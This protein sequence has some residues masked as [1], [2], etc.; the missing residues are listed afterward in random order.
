MSAV[1]NNGPLFNA[2]PDT[3]EEEF[4][5]GD[6]LGIVIE[7]RWLIIASTAIALLIGA[8]YNFVATP[9]YQA[10]GLLQVEERT[11]GVGDLDVATMFDTYTPPI[12]ELEILRSRTVLGTVVDD[13]GLQIVAQPNY[14]PIFG[15][16]LARRA[17]PD[18]RPL[19]KVDSLE[20]PESM[21]G[22]PFSLVALNTGS[23][24]LLGPEEELVLRGRIGEPASGNSVSLF[25]SQLQGEYGQQF[26][27]LKR[28]R[29]SSIRSLQNNLTVAE[30]G[31]W[32]GILSIKV[33]GPD[34][35]MARH[36]VDGIA[37]AYVRQNVE[38]KSEEAEKTLAFLDEQ[39]PIVKRDMEAAEVALNTY[40]LEQGSIDLPL[41]TQ[42][43]LQTIVKIEGQLNQLRQERDKVTQA[44]TPEHPTVI[45]LDT[46]I[47][48]LQAELED[49]ND[50]VREL[51]TTQQEVLRLVRDAEVNRALYTSLLN[52]AQELRVVKAGTVGNVRVLDYAVT[53]IAPIKP[54]KDNV[55]LL[56]LFFGGLTGMGLAFLR[57]A[58]HGG[59]VD[60]DLIEKRVNIPVYATI[61]HSKR[62]V[63]LYKKL[64]TKEAKRAILAVD[65]P[66]DSAIESIK[67]LTTALHFGMIDAKNSCI[68]IAGPSPEVGKSFV[69]INLAAALAAGG[70]TVLLI[71]GDLR[72]GHLHQY[73]GISRDNGLSE[74][75]SG[76]IPIGDALH[77]TTVKG[78]TFVPT[79]RIPPNP[80][81]LLLHKR[82]V[83]CLSVLTPRFDHIIIDSPPLLA[84]TDATI[85]GQ[86]AGA[87]L[88]VLRSGEHPMR[89][90]EQSV[91]RLQNANVNLRGIIVNDSNIAS[92]R[93]GAGKYSYQYT[94]DKA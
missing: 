62:Q 84:V 72:R 34:P 55:W 7:N 29:I 68:M 90:I 82:F 5:L 41:E 32:S 91:K 71:D 67:N 56:S 45:A 89:E 49:L 61:A 57:R 8:T 70:K 94:Y 39:L 88:L 73:L 35:D 86:M 10:D 2:A 65:S 15:A 47:V 60:P 81:E 92:R 58:L 63:R 25:V 40:R 74:F 46:Q 6:L 83:N 24:E 22:A 78:L 44:F 79:G 69:S 85:I 19:I 13:L 27:V 52:T 12:A 20:M 51:P 43:I 4:G 66:N 33:R 36:Q 75:V 37:N 21:I 1:V 30:K 3:D 14:F 31:E 23:Y 50:Q 16:A 38:R 9:I 80:A 64:E 48:R 42:S 93:Y 53:P 77:K 11:S 87:T 18:E 28:S 26:T 17:S 59:V 76:D 54:K